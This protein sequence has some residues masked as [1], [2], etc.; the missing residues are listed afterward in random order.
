LETVDALATETQNLLAH[1]WVSWWR[2]LDAYCLSN[3]CRR[4][5]CS[6]TSHKSCFPRK[7]I[8]H[9]DV[10]PCK[11]FVCTWKLDRE[12]KKCLRMLLRLLL[13]DIVTL[14]PIIVWEKYM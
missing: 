2:V 11:S 12:R 8:F 6:Y 5:K 7:W 1:L 13:M 14:Y 10:S 3:R 4:G 9:G